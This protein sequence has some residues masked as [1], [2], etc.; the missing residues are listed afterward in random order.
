LLAV[1]VSYAPSSG[2]P[3]EWL[4]DERRVD[5]VVATDINRFPQKPVNCN[6]LGSVYVAL[7]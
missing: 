3:L 2:L 1:A 4:T 7:A 6:R 5:T